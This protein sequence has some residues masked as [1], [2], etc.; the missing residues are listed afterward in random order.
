MLHFIRDRAQGWIAW[1]I[2][3]LISI[4]FALWGVNSYLTGPSDVVVAEVNGAPIKQAELQQSL[5]QYRNQM[6][7]MLGE[8][9]DPDMFEGPMVRRNVLDGLI[10]QK[11]IQDVNKAL[12]QQ[13][14][15]AEVS[16][17]IRTTPAFQRDGQ[18]DPEY[19]AMVLARAGYNPASYEAQ[20]RTDLLAQQ[21][22]QNIQTTAIA[23]EQEVDTLLRLEKQKRKI[24]YGV[25]P[26]Q[27]YLEQVTVSDDEVKQFFDNNQANYT[28]PEQIKLNYI[29]LS[30][31]EIAQSLDVDDTELKQFYAD[32]KDKFVGPEQ[33]RASHILIE[34]NDADALASIESIRQRLQQGEDFAALAKES[35][36]DPGSAAQGGDL[37]F[38][39]RDVMEPAFEEAVFALEQVGEISEPV[40]TE[41]GYHL[42]KLT[43]I[44]HA[45]GK[46][47]AEARDEVEALYRRQQAETV[48]YDKAEELANLSYEN[49]DNL[50]VAAE[51]L[52][53]DVKTTDSFTRS[54][55]ESGIASE[56]KVINAAFSEDVLQNN[57]N[58][59]VIE[60]SDT[61]LVVVHKNQHIPSTVLPFESVAPAIREQLKFEKASDLAREQGESILA[62]LK[63]GATAETL[64]SNWQAPAFYARNSKEISTQILQHAFS[65]P[66]PGAEPQFQGFTAN[67]GNYVLVKLTGVENGDPADV[68]QQEQQALKAQLARIQA[69]AE[70]Q[71]FIDSLRAEANIKIL[72]KTLR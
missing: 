42:I 49:P 5:Q 58:S 26:V 30:V 47:F 35:S 28:A 34:G 36:Q 54:G 8:Q 16:Q 14:S 12:G 38:F 43:G 10:E 24:A 15:D 67:N 53:L 32:N 66:K 37:G 70:L 68:A 51:A 2:V 72:D 6:R 39:Q 69:N 9:F 64:L 4:P 57:L 46:S 29:Q 1:F 63:S 19:Y 71:A 25:V 20:L 60:L 13:I 18:F 31:D 61:N 21:L 17:V 50:D 7:N 55:T 44:Q 65:M 62:E 40:K 48:F 3:G 22:M 41:F 45:E 59:A 27:D 56:Q 52:E 33:R 11:L 23:T